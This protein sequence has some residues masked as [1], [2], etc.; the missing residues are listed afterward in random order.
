LAVDCLLV[1]SILLGW[2]KWDK[3]ISWIKICNYIFKRIAEFKSI[4]E[5]VKDDVNGLL[6]TN[7]QELAN[8]LEV[9]LT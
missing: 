3:N 7:G 1:H 4:S 8:H 9:N 5:L 2:F 6:F